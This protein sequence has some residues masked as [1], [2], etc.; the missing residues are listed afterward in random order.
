MRLS[1]RLSALLGGGVQ[2]MADEI[3]YQELGEEQLELVVGGHGG[4]NTSSSRL[5]SRAT[6]G[7]APATTGATSRNLLKTKY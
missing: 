7:N 5:S 6:D 4:N 1:R 3:R 2:A